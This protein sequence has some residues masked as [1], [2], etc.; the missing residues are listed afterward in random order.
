MDCGGSRLRKI[1]LTSLLFLT[2]CPGSSTNSTSAAQ[3]SPNYGSGGY[4][5]R[6]G[7]GSTASAYNQP[8]VSS[9]NQQRYPN[10]QAQPYNGMDSGL[11]YS[12]TL[13]EGDQIS[14]PLVGPTVYRE[15]RVTNSVGANLSEE[16]RQRIVE[17]SLTVDVPEQLTDGQW[18]TSN[19]RLS[20][21]SK[22][23]LHRRLLSL[24][25]QIQN[26]QAQVQRQ[27][28]GGPPENVRMQ[29]Q[30]LQ[31]QMGQMQQQLQ[32]SQS[33]L[34]RI[35]AI[36]QAAPGEDPAVKLQT[37][38]ASAEAD[39]SGTAEDGGANTLYNKLL[40]EL[41][42]TDQAEA[43]EK[44]AELEE[45]AESASTA[46]AVQEKLQ[47]A[48][49][50]IDSIRRLADAEEDDDLIAIVQEMQEN[51]AKAQSLLEA[52]LSDLKELLPEALREKDLEEAITTLST[53]YTENPAVSSGEETESTPAVE[54]T[55]T[56]E[57]KA[58]EAA[59]EEKVKAE[60]EVKD[61][62]A[63]EEEVKDGGA[64]A[65]DIKAE[66]E[67][68]K[69]L[70]EENKADAKILN[71]IKTIFPAGKYKKDKLY[72]VIKELYTR[73]TAM[74]KAL[75]K[76]D[77]KTA[78]KKVVTAP[79]KL[80][81]LLEFADGIKDILGLDTYN[82]IL[83]SALEIIKNLKEGQKVIEKKVEQIRE[84]DTKV[85]EDR[86]GPIE[87]AAEVST[88]PERVI[89]KPKGEDW[90]PDITAGAVPETEENEG[91][92][93]DPEPKKEEPAKPTL[94]ERIQG[95]GKTKKK[96]SSLFSGLKP[97]KTLPTTPAKKPAVVRPA[98]A[99]PAAEKD[100]ETAEERT[101]KKE[102]ALQ[103]L[104][105]QIDGK[106]PAKAKS[107]AGRGVAPENTDDESVEPEPES[108][109]PDADSKDDSLSKLDAML[110][111]GL[112]FKTPAPQSA[113]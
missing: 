68:D 61:G 90:K 29:M 16:Q 50:T 100:A 11:G 97:E 38:M 85:E 106:G 83:P 64:G 62:E 65:K 71:D 39:S 42:V 1:I 2:G 51:A 107:L 78:G 4:G 12:P 109:V 28:G 48:Q 73:Y 27:G 92:S 45:A 9:Y 96:K 36:I 79:V 72:T 105:A 66:S 112:V 87:E 98:K 101:R 40:T 59:E 10:Q 113:S 77:I 43:L 35:K 82:N 20:Q 111:K 8:G 58:E 13:S 41:G 55:T 102:E 56:E 88:E 53:S 54:D 75:K 31:Q 99:A 74:Q 32:I 60:E 47:D 44:I 67:E 6:Y 52:K 30:Q 49:D 84:G 91:D 76:V 104:L 94:A 110:D 17:Q 108:R 46:D 103:K 80:K 37:I 14:G 19:I 70:A 34:E 26:L 15:S 23:D 95:L 93:S 81:Y 25:Q 69:K 86:I 24:Y 63:E 5:A 89:T 18:E 57:P 33:Q 3:I 21:I 22:L 7:G